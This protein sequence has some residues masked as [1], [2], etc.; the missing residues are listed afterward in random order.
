MVRCFETMDSENDRKFPGSFLMK[1]TIRMPRRSEKRMR[2]VGRALP[3]RPQSVDVSA[4]FRWDWD[5][6]SRTLLLTYEST[7]EQIPVTLRF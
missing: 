3:E 5:P 7:G 1:K 6:A 2:S 4:P